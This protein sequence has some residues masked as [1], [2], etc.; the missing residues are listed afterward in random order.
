M[1]LL[2]ALRGHRVRRSIRQIER[3]YHPQGRP[4]ADLDRTVWMLR[5]QPA[6]QSLTGCAKVGDIGFTH[7]KRTG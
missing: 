2:W 6:L 7:R 3:M 1:G 4:K 5:M